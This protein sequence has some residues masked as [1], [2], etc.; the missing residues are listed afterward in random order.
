[1][2][3]QPIKVIKRNDGPA[4]A[5]AA[6]KARKRPKKKPSLESTVKTWITERRENDEAEQRSSVAAWNTDTPA[7]TV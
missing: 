6:G 1:M 5:P 4:K 3:K 2:N 7:E